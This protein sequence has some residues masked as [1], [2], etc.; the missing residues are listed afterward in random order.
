MT[1][2][3]K[4]GHSRYFSLIAHRM[5]LAFLTNYEDH[6]QD[7][8]D[9]ALN[10]I[11]DEVGPCTRDWRCIAINLASQAACDAAH[12]LGEDAARAGT[13]QVIA[14]LLDAAERHGK[15]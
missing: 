10:A 4:F 11:T 7:A 2:F 6:D 12:S 13:Q 14:G 8:L 9:A 5:V 3:E 15:E 1:G